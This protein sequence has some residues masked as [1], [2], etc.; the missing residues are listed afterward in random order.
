MA[1]KYPSSED[2]ENIR[3]IFTHLYVERDLSLKD[4]MAM[5][6]E[7]YDF[8]AQYVFFIILL[9]EQ[10]LTYADDTCTSPELE[11]GTYSKI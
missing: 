1:K 7:E 5:L 10:I 9:I 11:N 8:H 4:V 3:P 6:A 2:W